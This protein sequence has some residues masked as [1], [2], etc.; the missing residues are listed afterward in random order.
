MCGPIPI[1]LTDNWI[2]VLIFFNKKMS[3]SSALDSRPWLCHARGAH[4]AQLRG[5]L[6]AGRSGTTLGSFY[7]HAILV[8]GASC[9]GGD[10]YL[11]LERPVL[12]PARH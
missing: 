5:E 11:L 6:Q 12:S 3:S 9:V 7:A 1:N 4:V 10:S 8:C 2:K